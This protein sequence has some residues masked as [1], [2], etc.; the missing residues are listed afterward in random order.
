MELLLRELSYLPLAIAQAAAYINTS[1]TSIEAYLP[2]VAQH[3][4]DAA[5]LSSG[6]SGDKLSDDDRKSPI[7]TT[8][9][10]SLER[11]RHSHRK[12]A[13]YLFLMACLDRKDI[14][15]DFLPSTLSTEALPQEREGAVAI[16]HRYALITRR[17]AISS[18]D[19][20]RLVHVAI[21]DWLK[22]NSWLGQ[23]TE[24]AM[25]CLLEVCP[26]HDYG[27]RSTWRRILPHAKHI[28]SCSIIAREDKTR[29]D[30]AWK[31]AVSLRAEGRYE[32]AEE[33]EVQVM[34]TR[35][36]VL[37][38]EHPDTLASMNNLAF[39]WKER[40]LVWKLLNLCMNVFD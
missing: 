23:W 4:E 37:G 7:T 14:L 33:L 38:E 26:D 1:E 8:L 32:E 28:L 39:T 5:Q 2:L 17:P 20:H 6:S 29:T 15:L 25:Y 35:M 13:E 11:L 34:E 10:V 40:A 22:R 31:C 24:S 27:T 21:R 9:L 30:L 36:R 18:V 3:K 19:L 16:L 12:A